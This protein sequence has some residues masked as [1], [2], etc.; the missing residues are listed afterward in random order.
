APGNQVE[1]LVSGQLLGDRLRELPALG[2][3]QNH[4]AATRGIGAGDRLDGAEDRLRLKNHSAAAA[5]GRLVGHA[6]PVV[7]EVTDIVDGKCPQSRGLHALQ[8][9][10]AEEPA[11]HLRKER[12][13]IKMHGTTRIV[14]L[15]CASYDPLSSASLIT[16]RPA[17]RRA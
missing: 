6:V 10:G 4:G 8:D 9:A 2:R 3:E 11:E 5:I 17:T 12:E 13:D 1:L 7:R 14:S 15:L 16:G